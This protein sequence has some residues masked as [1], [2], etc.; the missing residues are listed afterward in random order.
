MKIRLMQTCALLRRT[1]SWHHHLPKRTQIVTGITSLGIVASIVASTPLLKAMVSSEEPAQG[2]ASYYFYLP[3][4]YYSDPRELPVGRHNPPGGTPTFTPSLT[5]SETLAPATPSATLTTTKEPVS[6]TLIPSNTLTPTSAATTALPSAT[7][8]NVPPTATATNLPPT[9]TWTPVPPTATWTQ[10]P[11]TDTPVPPTATWTPVPPTDTPVP[12]TATWTPVPPTDTPVPPTATWTP[13]PPTD[14]PVPPTATWTPVPPTDTPVPPTA[15]WTPVPPTAT[16]TPTS[17]PTIAA[18]AYD[19]FSRNE[20][21]T[22]GNAPIGG[23]YTLWPNDGYSSFS[24]NGSVGQ[25]THLRGESRSAILNELA[26][27]DIDMRFKVSV[28]QLAGTNGNVYLYGVARRDE[29]A[30]SEYRAQVR[31]QYDGK[32]YMKVT[33]Y[34]N[35]AE[36]DV[37]SVSS[38]LFTITAGTELNVRFQTENQGDGSVQLRMKVWRSTDSEPTNWQLDTNDAPANAI[39]TAGGVG[40]RSFISASADDITYTYSFDDF[41]VTALP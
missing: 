24:V 41:I 25:F 11:P 39:T 35:N 4:V 17:T 6:P 37:G 1:Y 28:D 14:T 33:R 15:T 12:P 23:V 34:Q 21:D 19:D 18:I 40:L 32:V 7:A 29:V 3:L 36:I 13:V 20:S 27:D 9:A 31:I 30:K 5:P 38:S 22:W 16:Y 2:S 26:I 10:V 8:T